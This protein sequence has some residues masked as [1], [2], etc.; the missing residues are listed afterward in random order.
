MLLGD[1]MARAYSSDLRI[2]V[3][4]L[5][6]DG[7][8]ARGAGRRLGI[9]EPTATAWVGR[10]RRTG[11]AEAK[12]QKGRSRPALKPHAACLLALI[13]ERADLTLEQLRGLL[14][15]RGVRVGVSSIWRFFD[16]YGISFKKKPCTPPSSSAP[17]WSRHGWCGKVSGRGLIRVGW[18]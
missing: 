7:F 11:S 10:W 6:E 4:R 15:E 8:T 2:R 14:G 16:R 13:G 9:G 18:C 12:S 1:R 5:V 17:T 3:I